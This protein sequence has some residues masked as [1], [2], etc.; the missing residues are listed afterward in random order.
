MTNTPR[1]LKKRENVGPDC[2]RVLVS[3][4][5]DEGNFLKNVI[6]WSLSIQMSET[7]WGAY[8]SNHYI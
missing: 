1:N 6:S 5:K 8:Y 2:S 7:M 3:V 4:M